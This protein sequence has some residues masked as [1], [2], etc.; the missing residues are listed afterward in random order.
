MPPR[1]GGL[2]ARKVMSRLI[3]HDV[4]QVGFV[5]AGRDE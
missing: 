1:H 4:D 2:T 5:G 3:E